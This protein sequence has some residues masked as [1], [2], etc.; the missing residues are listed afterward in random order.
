MASLHNHIRRTHMR[1]RKPRRMLRALEYPEADANAHA[2][3]AFTLFALS[4]VAST[5]T[6]VVF[7]AGWIPLRSM[8][9]SQ[10]R[11]IESSKHNRNEHK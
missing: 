2:G 1:L 7:Y 3:A 9:D 8:P 5:T 11:E 4:T 6:L 10:I